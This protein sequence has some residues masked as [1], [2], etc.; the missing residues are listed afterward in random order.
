MKKITGFFAIALIVTIV[1]SCAPGEKQKEGAVSREEKPEEI[2]P[3]RLTK[4]ELSEGWFLLFDG[5]STSFWRGYN[6]ESFP[7]KGWTVEDGAL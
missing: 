2:L 4:Q 7:K 6:Q 3:N 1:F 5:Q